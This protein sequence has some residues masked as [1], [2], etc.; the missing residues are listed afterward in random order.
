MWQVIAVAQDYD[1][2]PEETAAHFGWPVWKVQAAFNYY[3]AF[4]EEIDRAIAENRSMDYE[5]M[6]RLFPH[7]R[8]VTF[9]RPAR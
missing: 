4:P 2:N 7:M 9:L 5:K 1:M 6:K 8:L 3:E